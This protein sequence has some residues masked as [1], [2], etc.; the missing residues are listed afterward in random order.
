[1]Y[2]KTVPYKLIRFDVPL[3]G[4]L[5]ILLRKFNASV[6]NIVLRRAM[7]VL[8]LIASTTTT[9]NRHVTTAQSHLNFRQTSQEV[10]VSHV[11]LL[12]RLMKRIIESNDNYH[13][14]MSLLS[15]FLFQN[16]IPRWQSWL[17]IKPIR[18][19]DLV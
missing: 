18:A 12:P 4:I 7:F 17:P 3:F 1:M 14:F 13:Y 2:L 11:D 5:I 10:H 16:L 6:I 8:M 19:W 9:D 15:L